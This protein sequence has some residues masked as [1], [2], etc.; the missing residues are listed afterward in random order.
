MDDKQLQDTIISLIVRIGGITSIFG[1]IFI[2]LNYILFSQLRTNATQKILFLQGASDFT[3]GLIY[4]VLGTHIRKHSAYL[5][6]IQGYLSTYFDLFSA[7]LPVVLISQIFMVITGIKPKI[8]NIF[9]TI[10]FG[11]AFLFPMIVTIVVFFTEPIDE[12][13]DGFYFFKF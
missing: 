7:I 1:G 4:G 6:Q 3:L 12:I 5:C 11:I 10:S 8:R 13:L 2:M 9:T